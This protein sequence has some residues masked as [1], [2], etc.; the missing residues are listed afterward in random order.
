[1]SRLRNQE[2][3]QTNR[4]IVPY[5]TKENRNKQLEKP[6]SRREIN[7]TETLI[8]QKWAQN[9]NN[10]FLMSLHFGF[11]LCFNLIIYFHHFVSQWWSRTLSYIL[12]F[13]KTFISPSPEGQFNQV[14][15]VS[16]G[17]IHLGYIIPFLS[18]LQTFCW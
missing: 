8:H 17:F 11:Y 13:G 15:H 1:M 5:N 3:P 18:G 4:L 2:I 14:L 9:K 16:F 12:T 6:K 7:K 10:E